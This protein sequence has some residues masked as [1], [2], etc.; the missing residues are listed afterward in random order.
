MIEYYKNIL[1]KKTKQKVFNYVKKEVK[2]LGEDYPCFQTDPDLHIKPEMKEFVD[3]VSKY[4]EPY[5]I[6]KM[7]CVCSIG[8]AFAWHDHS[9]YKYSFVY[10]LHNPDKVGTMFKK[11]SKHNNK[12][13][14]SK[15]DE[16]TMI[17]FDASLTHS[18]PNTYKRIKRYTIAFDVI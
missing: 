12:V 5:T 2:D 4:V 10:F 13:T 17:K 1:D 16:N 11:P 6:R 15:G 18:P 3:I 7:W 9:K 14:Y 8:D